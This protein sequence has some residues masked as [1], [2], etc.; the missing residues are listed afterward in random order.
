MRSQAT[1]IVGCFEQ[2]NSLCYFLKIYFVLWY[3]C[4]VYMHVWAPYV[5]LVS[6]GQQEAL[7][8]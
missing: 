5:C 7:N 6:Q 2:M 8:P 4:T 3:D 1:H